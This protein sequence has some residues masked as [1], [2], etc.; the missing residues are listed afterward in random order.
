MFS[1]PGLSLESQQA[2]ALGAASFQG[3]GPRLGTR[4]PEDTL[5]GAGWSPQKFPGTLHVL[6]NLK[7]CPASGGCGEILLVSVSAVSVGSGSGPWTILFS[8]CA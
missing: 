6:Q 8:F 3:V 5:G 1:L 2:G 7:L 4:L